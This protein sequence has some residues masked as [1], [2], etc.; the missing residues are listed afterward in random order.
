MKKLPATERGKWGLQG[1]SRDQSWHWLNLRC[2]RQRKTTSLDLGK[3]DAFLFWSGTS[4]PGI[5]QRVKIRLWGFFQRREKQNGVAW[6]SWAS[7]KPKRFL[8]E[9]GGVEGPDSDLRHAGVNPSIMLLEPG[10]PVG[11]QGITE[12]RSGSPTRRTLLN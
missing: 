2:R 10:A 9:E 4:G 7:H 6:D 1:I 12:A 11:S 5:H 8:Q 3:E